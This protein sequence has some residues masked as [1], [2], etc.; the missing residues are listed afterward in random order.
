VANA[1]GRA[2]GRTITHIEPSPAQHRAY[3]ARSGRGDGYVNHMLHLFELI[4]AGVFA[5]VT[6]DFERLT[7]KPPRTLQQYADE[8]W[9]R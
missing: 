3:F 7:G 8:A 5:T 1:I 6:D 4:R 9:A 2:A